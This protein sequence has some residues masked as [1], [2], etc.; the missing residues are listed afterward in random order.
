MMNALQKLTACWLLAIV[1]SV[2]QAQEATVTTV[3]GGLL[4]PS[5]VAI[6]PG[7]GHVF[8]SDSGALRVLDI[9]P[10]NPMKH[11][12]AVKAFPKDVYGKG[13]MYDIGPL[14]LL[15]VDQKTLVVGDGGQVDGKE[16]VRVYSLPP[17]GTTLMADDMKAK[18]GPITPSEASLKGEGNFYALASNGKAIFVTS[19][20]DDTKGWI[21]KADLSSTGLGKLAPFIAT[22]VATNVDAPVGI[23]LN[24]AGQIV[25]GQMGEINVMGDSL[26]TIYDASSGKLVANGTTGLYD[27]VALAYHPKSDALYALDYGWMDVT[28][29]G[30]Y[31]LDVAQAGDKLT[32]KPTLAA[33]LD[34]PTAMA[35]ATDGTLYVTTIGT[36]K[37]EERPGSLVKVTGLP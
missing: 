8:V 14:G 6:Q 29:G 19:N 16:L 20:G 7:T 25:V 10:A 17:G 37:A 24:K 33:K 28:K 4:N 5:G 9:D 22:K 13:P 21:L 15:F 27:I 36:A 26:L 18:L 23:T 2:I 30:L 35:F 1:P 3:L 12:S 31:R 32:V 11:H 34:K